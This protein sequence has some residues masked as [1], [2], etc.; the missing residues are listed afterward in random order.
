MGTFVRPLQ[1]YLQENI[2]SICQHG[3][4][5]MFNIALYNSIVNSSLVSG[6]RLSFIC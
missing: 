3:F 2:I 1:C 6:E 5:E 4:T